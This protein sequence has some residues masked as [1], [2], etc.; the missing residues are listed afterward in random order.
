MNYIPLGYNS[1]EE[2]RERT[3]KSKE[4]YWNKYTERLSSV[5]DT[6]RAQS[7]QDIT[8]DLEILAT[9][10]YDVTYSRENNPNLFTEADVRQNILIFRQTLNEL[11]AY[12]ERIEEASYDNNI[13]L[14]GDINAVL[15]IVELERC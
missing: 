8:A 6:T 1:I 12:M 15:D 7:L 9:A 2:Y 5:V 4:A 3:R 10:L 14:D 13:Y 11:N